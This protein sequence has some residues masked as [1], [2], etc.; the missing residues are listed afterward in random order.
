[1]SQNS[2][3]KQR[4]QKEAQ[5]MNTSGSSRGGALQDLIRRALLAWNLLWDGRVSLA[6]K[7]IPLGTL[8]YIVSPVDFI[9]ELALGPIGALD[10]IGVLL[11]G[12][13]LFIQFAPPSVV[14]D[15]LRRLELGADDAV[16]SDE[17]VVDGS[18]R[19]V[20]E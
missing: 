16:P 15:H 11:L 20:D 7:L 8:I 19:A 6:L 3:N 14:A 17:D 18:A 12:L 9:P 13:N 2:Q 4:S 5:L 10:D 1:M